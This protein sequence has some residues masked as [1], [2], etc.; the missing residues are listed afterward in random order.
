MIYISSELFKC[1]R[2]L[3]EVSLLTGLAVGAV[4]VVADDQVVKLRRRNQA[5]TL[6][7]AAR[8]SNSVEN[9]FAQR[10]AAWPN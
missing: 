6:R 10:F 8:I 5:E 4:S 3:V 9:C 1:F 2:Q 7:V